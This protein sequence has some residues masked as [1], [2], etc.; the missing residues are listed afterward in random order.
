MTDPPDPRLVATTLAEPATL[1][2]GAHAEAG[3]WLTLVEVTRLPDGRVVS[4]AS[5]EPSAFYLLTA[6]ALRDD[7]VKALGG[8]VGSV[9]TFPAGDFHVLNQSLLLDAFGLIAG[10]VLLSLAA[11]EAAANAAIDALPEGIEVTVERQGARVSVEKADMARRLNLSEKVDRIPPLASGATSIKGTGPW[12]SFVALRRLRDDLVHVKERG[13]SSD[14]NN[15]SPFG[16]IFRG[17]ASRCV[18][19][20]TEVIVAAWPG[21][22]SDRARAVLAPAASA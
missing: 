9:G 20:A 6:K 5:P 13:Y 18:E 14:P 19:Q 7:G 15:P 22:L 10:A 16:R 21:W 11:I 4:F 1:P 12:E 2:S 17:D 3:A 8:A